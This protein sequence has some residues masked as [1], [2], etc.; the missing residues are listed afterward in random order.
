MAEEKQNESGTTLRLLEKEM[1]T[2][3]M[4]YAMSVIVGRALPDVRDGLKPVHRRILYAMNE[5][6]MT[7][8][9]PHKKSA[10]VV[11][12]VLG[13]F[14]PHGDSAIYDSLV[15]MAQDF[16]LRYPLIDGQGNFGSVDADPPAAMR[17]TE[18]RMSKISDELLCDIEKETV[19]FTPNFDASLQE[20][21]VLPSK[22]PNLLING[23]SGIAVGMATNIPPY[24]LGETVD[25]L[26]A[27]IDSP[28]ISNEEL[29]NLIPG[30]DFPTGAQILGRGGCASSFATGRG[31]MRMRAVAEIKEQKKTG[32]KLIEITELPYQVNKAQL[33][34]HIATLVNEKKLEGISDVNDRSDREG[35]CIEIEI[36]K[37]ADANIVL[38]QLYAHTALE[39][40]FGAI[41]LALVDGK[42]KVL[43]IPDMLREFIKHR[44]QVVRKRSLFELARAEERSHILEG[45]K[46]AL[47]NIDAIVK[48]IKSS[49]NAQA[50]KEL[51]MP[52]FSLSEKQANAILEMKLARLTSLEQ[53][54]IVQE[55]AELQKTIKWL[56][57]VLADE[58]KILEI[59]KKESLEVK[60]KY[61]D[62]R[63][64]KI[65]E[66]EG[67]LEVEDLIADEKVAVI[68]TQSDYIKRIP[69]SEYRTQ[70]RGGKGVIGTETKEEDIAKDILIAS[71]HDY[72]LFFT[73]KGT[74]H[75]LKVYR[76]P[77][78]GR[79]A[80]G[81]S[82]VNLLEVEN[83]K[84]ASWLPVREFKEE[85]SILMATEKGM[86][87]KSGIMEYSRPRKGGIIAIS[88][89]END[90]LISV[91]K[92]DGKRHI[93]LATRKGYAIKFAEEDVRE[94]GRT[95]QGVIGIRLEEDD[96]VI[97]MAV[98]D[99]PTLLTLTEN[100]FGKRT[101]LEEY[102]LQGRGGY[103]VY[104]IK[105]TDRNGKAIDIRTV[106][107]TDELFLISSRGKVIRTPASDISVIGRN[108]AGVRIMRLEEGEKVAA[109][110]RLIREG[111]EEKEEGKKEEEQ[112]KSGNGKDEG[113]E[114]KKQPEDGMEEGQTKNEKEEKKEEKPQLEKKKDDDGIIVL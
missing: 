19:S 105:T 34:E 51:L 84:I 43:P 90:R 99:R 45:L 18:A 82:I 11:G 24:N 39:S 113:K 57:E 54:K 12:E 46:I 70:K 73:D 63:R 108:T 94:I 79:Y 81:R 109:V 67:D 3:Y 88:L 50:A 114:E 49:K 14:H 52:N 38:N 65:V 106:S 25:A 80:M 66:F 44:Q 62:E 1:E 111:E 31:S 110:A 41:N 100:G 17:Y 98:N 21:T 76:I 59:I 103:G 58:Q 101:S 64:T 29:I 33:I 16:S 10:R 95:G 47:S 89:K 32:K 112:P 72:L 9:K 6:G 92:T 74:V 56:K 93:L 85:D 36:K 96:A 22:I 26:V 104:S 7:H 107:D 102:R 2:S 69:L 15:R 8:D 60:E 23:S 20:P 55:H 86:V 61:A 68:I 48:A 4:D 83:E 35:M 28:Q 97:G 13:K 42:P 30:P 71:T 78:A 40:S 75:W 53:E 27:L 87:K 5:L 91:R 77:S 37:N